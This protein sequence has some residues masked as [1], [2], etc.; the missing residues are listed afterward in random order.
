MKMVRTVF[1]LL[2]T[3]IIIR[4]LTIL[5]LIYP[6]IYWISPYDLIL[7][8]LHN[9]ESTLHILDFLYYPNLFLLPWFIIYY[10][11]DIS[12]KKRKDEIDRLGILAKTG[13]ISLGIT[14]LYSI[15][16]L[17]FKL[18]GSTNEFISE[19]FST[20]SVLASLVLL[21]AIVI[22]PNLKYLTVFKFL[23]ISKFVL[24]YAWIYLI[25]NW[26][27]IIIGSN[28]VISLTG[29]VLSNLLGVIAFY[30]LM[31]FLDYEL[32]KQKINL[33]SN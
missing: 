20:I 33:N 18:S 13:M 29:V 16:N 17:V 15:F 27:T 26:L 4:I 30:F 25:S 7:H 10:S 11:L 12:N 6:D 1:V 14:F 2:I 28:N 23:L 9:K 19:T 3:L 5:T 21:A 22:L 31:K 32:V 8:Y 24:N